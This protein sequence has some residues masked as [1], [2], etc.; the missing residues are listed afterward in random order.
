MANEEHLAI[1]KQGVEAWNKWQVDNWGVKQ[2]RVDLRGAD[3]S[4]ADLSRADR[5][6]AD[7]S[8]ADLSRVNLIRADL[9]EAN[10]SEANLSRANLIGA[11]LRD[12]NLSGADLS[13]VNLLYTIL[14]NLDL[15][16]TK[17]L[18]TVRH[19]GPSPISTST[20][21]RSK[22]QI[23]VEFL[24]GCGL[25]DL[26][27]EYAKLHNP[28][29]TEPQ[30]TDIT[31]KIHNLLVT[32]AIH[33]YSCFISYN[34]QDQPFAQRLYDNLQDSGVRC[35]FAPEDI[36][37][38]DKLRPT[39]DQSIR[40]H[41]KLLLV[42]SEHSINS[43]WVETEVETAFEKERQ[44]K[45]MVLFPIRLDEAVMETKQAWA[46][47]VRRRHIGDFTRWS[48]EDAYGEALGRLL[49]DLRG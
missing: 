49:E 5:I 42:L 31:Y 7:L 25:S 38:G 6:R 8:R 46:G 37:I 45:Q 28:D 2:E 26:D 32:K 21:T 9:S 24:R 17:G 43:Q 16:Q 1:L 18:D 4:D 10:L 27:I 48:N 35:W 15:S 13:G 29:L 40:L 34:H 44:Q 47:E 39:I 11:I 41:D 30:I 20:L 22:G 19:I 12:A 23:P 33:F 36:K 3:L 14:A